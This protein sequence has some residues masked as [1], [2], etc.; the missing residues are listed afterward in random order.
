M[1]GLDSDDDELEQDVPG[2][3]NPFSPLSPSMNVPGPLPFQANVGGSPQVT[4]G[5]EQRLMQVLESVTLL[6]Q[7]QIHGSGSSS[8]SSTLSGKDLAKVLKAPERFSATSREAELAQWPNWSWSFE[9]WLC[10]VQREFFQDLRVIRASMSTPIRMPALSVD[11]ADRSRLMFGIL[12]GM[13]HEKGQRLLR[14][15]RIAVGSRPIASC[16]R[17]S[18][19]VQGPGCCPLCRWCTVGLHSAPSWG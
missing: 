2:V 1:A 6:L 7:N 14:S 9:Q 13:L 8:S 12:S 10:C 18:L 4:Q 17:T 19:Q 11:E 3:A 15:I 16:C 5:N